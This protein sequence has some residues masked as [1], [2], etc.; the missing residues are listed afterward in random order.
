MVFDW[1]K[2]RAAPAAEPA[3]PADQ[4]EPASPEPSQIAK[5]A[6]QTAV[7][8]PSQAAPLAAPAPL[9]PELAAGG[10]DQ[11][12]LDWARQAYARLKAEQQAK[13]E[14]SPTPPAAELAPERTGALPP[15]QP[16]QSTQPASAEPD[17]KPATGLSLLEQAAAARQQ[18][19]SELQAPELLPDPIEPGASQSSTAVPSARPAATTGAGSPPTPAGQLRCRV[20]L[21]G[22]G[23]G[24]PGAPRRSGVA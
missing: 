13:Q 17:Q 22:R 5:Q 6:S 20:Q 21:V 8:A 24:R 1:F 16:P 14:P 15:Q 18:R 2:R 23:A 12:A 3:S 7:E 10:V 4:A 19:Q 11:D 9:E